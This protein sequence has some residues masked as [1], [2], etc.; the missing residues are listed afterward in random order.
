MFKF[1]V[2]FNAPNTHNRKEII[3][4]CNSYFVLWLSEDQIRKGIYYSSN[5]VENSFIELN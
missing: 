3:Y 4:F 2:A 1:S 5:R